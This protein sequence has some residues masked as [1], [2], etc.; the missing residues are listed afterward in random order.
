M[1]RFSF[2]SEGINGVPTDIIEVLAFLTAPGTVNVTVG[3]CVTSQDMPVASCFAATILQAL[4][5]DAV[6]NREGV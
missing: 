3:G 5:Q 2:Q 1:V 6:G 4:D